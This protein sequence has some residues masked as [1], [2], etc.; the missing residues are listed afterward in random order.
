MQRPQREGGGR[1][2]LVGRRVEMCSAGESH[3]SLFVC[4]LV[5]HISWNVGPLSLSTRVQI[6]S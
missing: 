6:H 4:V 3:S 5:P 1:A 2:L